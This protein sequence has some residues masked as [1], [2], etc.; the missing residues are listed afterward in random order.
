MGGFKRLESMKK[1]PKS[2][3]PVPKTSQTIPLNVIVYY[4]TD[5]VHKS[6]KSPVY[7]VVNLKGTRIKF[8]T[9]VYIPSDAWVIKQ[10]THSF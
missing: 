3:N 7:L 10:F 1:E 9:G 6:G 2:T 4:R 5:Y 8:N